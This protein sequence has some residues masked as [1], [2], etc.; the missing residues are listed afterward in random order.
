MAPNVDVWVR[1]C[2]CMCLRACVRFYERACMD[3]R[4]CVW[5]MCCECACV[6][7]RACLREL[8]IKCFF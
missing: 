3:V 4:M 2:T 7:C 6:Y 5:W 1:A 8:C